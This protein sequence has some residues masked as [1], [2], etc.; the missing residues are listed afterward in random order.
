[1]SFSSSVFIV[2][3]ARD[4]AALFGTTLVFGSLRKGFPTAEVIV[5]DNDSVPDVKLMSTSSW[6]WCLVAPKEGR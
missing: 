5:L 1:M 3:H 4:L 6:T 2:T